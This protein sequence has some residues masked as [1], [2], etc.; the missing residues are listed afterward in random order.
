MPRL[1]REWLTDDPDPM[2]RHRRLRGTLLFADVSGFTKMSERLSRHGKVGA[3]TITEVIETC[4]T[5]LLEVAHSHGGTLLQFSGDAVLLFYRGHGHELRAAA[6]ALAMRRKLRSLAELT[7]Q[8]AGVRLSM[9]VGVHTGDF[10]FFLVGRSHRQLVLGG[11]AATELV[12]LEGTAERGQI[13]VSAGTVASLPQRNLG[14][15]HALGRMLVGHIDTTTEQVEFLRVPLDMD[16]FVAAGLRDAV[17]RGRVDSEHRTA[18]VA[19]VEY[20]GLDELIDRAGVDEAGHRLDELMVATQ[21]AIDQRGVCFQS[22]D[23][24]VDGGKF[25]LSAGAPRT[26]GHDEEQMLLALHDIVGIDVG[27]PLRAGVNSG[28]VFTGQISSRLR[29]TFVTMGDPVNVAARVMSKAGPGTVYATRP[30][31]DRSR[32]LFETAPVSP[33]MVKGK[34]KPIEAFAVGAARGVRTAIAESNLPLVGRDDEMRAFRAACDAAVGGTGRYLQVVADAGAGKS[35]LLDEFE[36]VS[37]P[38]RFHRVRCRLYQAS[39]PY[40]PFSELLPALL[41]VAPTEVSADALEQIVKTRAPELL[42][43]LALLGTV[44][45][46]DIAPS[47]DVT[48]LE[49]EFR[50]AQLESAVVALLT[51]VLVEPVVV[52][53]EDAHW[54]DDA[55]CELFDALVGGVAD[56]PWVVLVA[57]RR[58]PSG[59]T[60][61]IR[62]PDVRLDLHPLGPRALTELVAI[63]TAA[64]PLPQHH[65][66]TLVSRSGG[67]PLFLLELLNAARNGGDLDSLPT[68]VEGLLTTRIDRL[69]AA[70]RT[71]LRHISVLGAGFDVR[72]VDD[73][74]PDGIEHWDDSLARLD[75]FVR[76]DT[77]GWVAFRHH[78]V[79]DVA[80][81][82]LPYRVRRELHQRVAESIQHRVGDDIDDVAPLL[83]LHFFRAGRSDEAWRFSVIAG[84]RARSIFANVDAIALYRRALHAAN[85]LDLDPRARA[86]VLTSLGDVED[87]TGVFADARRSYTAARHLVGDDRVAQARLHLRTAFIDE[88]LGRF[89]PAVRSIR[90]GLRALDTVEGDDADQCRADLWAWYAAIRLRQGR[91][92]EAATA[93]EDAIRLAAPR[94]DS[95]TTARALMTL[96]FAGSSLGQDVD[97]GGTRR[98]LEIST[99]LGDIGGEA[100]AANVLGGYAY[101]AGGWDDAVA[102]YRRSRSAR[103]RTGDP[104]GVATANANLAEILIEQGALG[105]ADELLTAASA[106]WRASDD[107]WGAAFADRLRGIAR[108]RSGDFETADALLRGARSGFAELGAAPDVIEADVAIGELLLLGGRPAAAVE[109]LDAIVTADPTK[110]GVEHLVPAVHRLRGTARAALSIDDGD[111]DLERALHVA[112]DRGADHEIA[113]ALR[114]RQLVR[115]WRGEPAD[116]A[117]VAECAEI[118]R[119]LGLGARLEARPISGSGTPGP[120]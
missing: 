13:L 57:Q 71:L 49:P 99:A 88:R 64:D 119:R 116:A 22:A 28:S 112:R 5:E 19:F 93:S 43:W 21:A 97:F 114:A 50:R 95:A 74:A 6:A 46:L 31:L 11:A 104:V 7:Q 10:D 25:Y 40:F 77:E 45:G 1:V 90:R 106:A 3:E 70:E 17:S 109:L 66:E 34:S 2:R 87:L 115:S 72:Y 76:H 14:A 68:T 89:V 79:R 98:A 4:F 91:F 118:E 60:E 26:T 59:P 8:A 35:R 78:L 55:S 73:V 63:I 12:R 41:G 111:D 53:C 113:L 61:R 44:C 27:L 9:T 94:G 30:V 33:F 15:R 62:A 16:G 18:T 84:D 23:L 117:E 120:R 29:S 107:A 67:N 103:E 85:Q 110:A 47:A 36:T 58:D 101:F 56:R 37:A 39:T 86:D 42:P 102:W 52:C 38:L 82:G 108:V 96:D 100:T 24:A 51:A 81:E 20:T 83:S 48:A 54:M 75:E 80:Y 65:V 105:E 92:V 32:T 69:A